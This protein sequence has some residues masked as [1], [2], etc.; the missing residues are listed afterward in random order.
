MACTVAL[1]VV[2]CSCSDSVV[3]SFLFPFWKKVKSG[4]AIN[5]NRHGHHAGVLLVCHTSSHLASPTALTDT[6]FSV[7]LT[8]PAS[9]TNTEFSV[10]LTCPASLTDTEFSVALTCHSCLTDTEFSVVLTCPAFPYWHWI[11]RCS[12]MSYFPYWHWIFRCSNM[13]FLPHWHWISPCSNMSH[14]QPCSLWYLCHTGKSIC[15]YRYSLVS[16]SVQ[17]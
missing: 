1:D 2:C 17:C 15:I 14:F 11:F 3:Y 4:T 10:A 5:S 7:V 13:T 6:E 16:V 12:N 9:L 8:C